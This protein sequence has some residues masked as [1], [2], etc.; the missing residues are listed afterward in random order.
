MKFEGFVGSSYKLRATVAS[1]QRTVNLY[2][3]KIEAV[4]ENEEYYLVGTDGYELFND[5]AIQAYPRGS[6]NANGRWFIATYSRLYEVFSDATFVIRGNISLGTNTVGMADNGFQLCVACG[7]HG[8]ILDLATNTFTEITADGWR[9][10]VCV[11]FLNGRFYFVDTNTGIYFW[12]ALYD[13]LDIDALNF[14]TDETSPDNLLLMFECYQDIYAF[15]TNSVTVYYPNDDANQPISITQGSTMEVGLAAINSVAKA[16]NTI[17]F[18]SDDVRGGAV[19][20]AI[21]GYQLQK[22]SNSAVEQS[23]QSFNSV[24]DATA[25][26]Y[27]KDGHTFYVVNFSSG[28]TTWAYDLSTGLWCERAYLNE[29]GQLEREKSNYHTYIFGNHYLI[30][31]EEGNIYRMDSDIYTHNGRV[32]KRKRVCPHVKNEQKRIRYYSIQIDMEVGVGNSDD[33]DPLAT[34]RFSKDGGM[35]YGPEHEL[36]IGAVGQYR[37]RVKFNRIGQARDL[38]VDYEVTGKTKCNLLAAY[39]EA[40]GSGT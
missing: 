22:I 8:Y 33:P 5:T 18:V 40:D 13:G 38:V 12:S 24:S 39:I 34:I 19:V 27:Q 36:N 26:S 32:I 10:S 3:E 7:D 29:D 17:F 2:P 1:A 16:G 14:A 21:T 35:T 30:D 11:T 15:G 9:G 20:Y 4:G 31:A 23:M 37:K 25:Y 6:Y 28:N